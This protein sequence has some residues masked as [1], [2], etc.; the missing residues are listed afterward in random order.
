MK[1]EL[2]RISIIFCLMMH[3]CFAWKLAL[4]VFLKNS[5]SKL[6]SFVHT[7]HGNLRHSKTSIK[8]R[9]Q[10]IPSKIFITVE[11]LFHTA[12]LTFYYYVF[13]VLN[14]ISMQNENMDSLPIV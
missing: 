9:P 8:P 10:H 5:Y 6:L 2:I 7:S 11:E 14:A 3:I 4:N 12:V 13:I 1:T